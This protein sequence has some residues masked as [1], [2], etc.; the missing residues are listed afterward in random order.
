MRTYEWRTSSRVTNT[1]ANVDPNPNNAQK[2]NQ[3]IKSFKF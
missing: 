1:D 2:N 3:K